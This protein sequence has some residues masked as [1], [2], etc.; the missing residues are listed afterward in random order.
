MEKPGFTVT[1]TKNDKPL[2]TQFELRTPDGWNHPTQSMTINTNDQGVV[3]ISAADAKSHIFRWYSKKRVYDPVI[4]AAY[5]FPKFGLVVDGQW[6]DIG[7]HLNPIY[8]QWA[9]EAEKSKPAEDPSLVGKEEAKSGHCNLD[10]AQALQRAALGLKQLF[11][12]MS[13]GGDWFRVVETKIVVA[14]EQGAP[15][16][17]ET[18]VGGEMHVLVV[19]FDPVRLSI[20][21]DGYAVG[22]KSP[23]EVPVKSTTGAYTASL[24][25]QANWSDGM[26][27]KV[28]G[29]GCTL[30]A[31]VHKL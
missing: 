30:V 12:A 6:L 25:V 9:D 3:R 11:D 8:G 14:T 5:E 7:S 22:T 4:V 13:S 23:Y 18:L 29:N 16:E 10:R 15:V 20:S 21:S 31:F 1:L 2:R 19:G 26:P 24:A 17:V 28:F 27:T